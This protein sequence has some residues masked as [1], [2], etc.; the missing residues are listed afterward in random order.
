MTHPTT[1]P[2]HR[3]KLF[4]LALALPFLLGFFSGAWGLKFLTE[5]IFKKPAFQEVREGGY[6]FINPLLECEPGEMP[7]ELI[8]FKNKIAEAVQAAVQS[9]QAIEVGVYFRDLNNGPWFGINENL[10]F[11]PASLLKVPIMMAYFKKAESDPGLLKKTLTY[12]RKMSGMEQHFEPSEVLTP[13]ESY[14]IKDLIGRMI[15]YSDNEAKEMLVAYDPG[16]FNSVQK[17]LGM[18]V[19]EYNEPE[20]A[21]SVRSYASLF[22]ILYNASYLSPEMSEKALKILSKSQFPYGLVTSVPEGTKVAHKFGERYERWTWQ[23][24]DCG[25]IYY[26]KH[27]YLLCILTRGADVEALRKVIQNISRIV[28]SEVDKQSR[29][30]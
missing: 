29:S 27:P 12:E 24:H 28:Y 16:S 22:R 3:T 1:A 7:Q 19:W 2:G 25:I 20:Q 18:D 17:S 8:P 26:P 14:T 10:K 23:L 15:K 11:L 4:W 9:K 5:R 30:R 21:I 6:E 13:G